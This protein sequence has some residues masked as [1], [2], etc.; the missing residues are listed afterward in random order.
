MIVRGFGDDQVI[1]VRGFTRTL[2]DEIIAEAIA[3]IRGGSKAR[4]KLRKKLEEELYEQTRRVIVSAMLIAVNDEEIAHPK[5]SKKEIIVEGQKD[6]DIEISS[7][8]V[9]YVKMPVKNI[10]IEAMKIVKYRR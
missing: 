7:W 5:S 3:I 6:L 9:K 10:I 8:F 2:T 4:R 1:V